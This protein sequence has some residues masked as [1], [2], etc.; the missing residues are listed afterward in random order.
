MA[1][2]DRSQTSSYSSFIVNMSTIAEIFNVEYWLDV[3]IWV[4]GR[5]RSSKILP[6]DATLYWSAVLT[7]ALS[8]TIF[9]LVDVQNIDRPV[10]TARTFV[11]HYDDTQYCIRDSS[12]NI[13]LPLDQQHISDAAKW[14]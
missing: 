3:E 13:P 7:I 9:E 1:P 11:Y 14:R 8:C 6:I 10:R 4:R 5:A 2:F 12:V